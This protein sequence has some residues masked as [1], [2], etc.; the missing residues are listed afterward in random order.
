MT[1]GTITPEEDIMLL[2]EG[3]SKKTNLNK[4]IF[5]DQRTNDQPL[6][7]SRSDVEGLGGRSE[8]ITTHTK[9]GSCRR[10]DAH[11]KKWKMADEAWISQDIISEVYPILKIF[12]SM[13][14]PFAFSSRTKETV[15]FLK[16][17]I[18]FVED[19][20]QWPNLFLEKKKKE[21]KHILSSG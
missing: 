12:E 2:W 10:E 6:G 5:S 8:G 18:K 15:S 1:H 7:H 20:R 19:Y 17:L 9:A 13:C 16:N 4:E 11:S 21:K 3:T 14:G